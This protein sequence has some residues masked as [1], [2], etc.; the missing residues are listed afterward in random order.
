MSVSLRRGLPPAAFYPRRGEPGAGRP[1]LPGVGGSKQDIACGGEVAGG[2]EAGVSRRFLDSGSFLPP[3]A[4]APHW[5]S[6]VPL[7]HRLRLLADAAA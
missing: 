4:P 6:S 2:R 7:S 3:P 5:L 1:E